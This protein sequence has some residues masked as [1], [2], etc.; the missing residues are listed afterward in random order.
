MFTHQTPMPTSWRPL[1]VFFPVNSSGTDCARRR[2]CPPFLREYLFPPPLNGED[3]FWQTLSLPFP[4]RT[5][6]VKQVFSPVRVKRRGSNALIN[7]VRV[8]G[9]DWEIADWPITPVFEILRT[10]VK[11]N[12]LVTSRCVGIWGVAPTVR[13]SGLAR[14]A[15]C[16]WL[17]SAPC[18][19]ELGNL[20]PAVDCCCSTHRSSCSDL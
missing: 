15:R 12:P 2:L 9:R 18:Y 7:A 13:I 14:S 1:E 10:A 4:V 20:V 8:C 16:V 17:S 19:Q 3:C 5:R 6:D 11:M